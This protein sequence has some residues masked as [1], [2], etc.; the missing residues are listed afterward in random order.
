MAK[1]L[2]VDDELRIRELIKKYAEFEGHTAKEAESGNEALDILKDES[3]DLI[4]LDVMMPGINGFDTAKLIRQK[5]KTPIIILSAKGEEYD[6]IEGFESGIDDY[7]VKPFSPKELMM[8]I[9]AILNRTNRDN[10]ES[11]DKFTYKGLS[12][13]FLGR[14]V[15]IDGQRVEMT[16][17][18]YDLLVFLIQNEN[19]ALTRETLISKVWGYDF[20]GDDRTLDTH[21][22]LLRKSLGEYANL[23]ITLRGVGYRFEREE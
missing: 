5:D 4:I 20:F 16:P 1:L 10:K 18:E 8:R 23:I 6:K 13:D 11:E 15:T 17:K 21:V 12:I 14:I 22:K 19:I 9:T 7:V 3:F 2:I